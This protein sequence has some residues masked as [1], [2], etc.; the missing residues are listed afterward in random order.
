[1]R[2]YLGA[3]HRGFQLK[4]AI[5]ASVLQSGYQVIDASSTFIP[6]DDYPAIGFTVAEQTVADP[7]AVGIVCCGSGIG[8]SI[9][10][11]KIAGARAGVGYSSDQVRASR[12]DDGL[13]ILAV[14]S[15]YLSQEEALQLVEVFLRTEVGQEE[16]HLRRR[17]E[18]TLKE[19]H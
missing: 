4:E 7:A 16:R 9:A 18:I 17:Q 1:M 13:N 14:A 15:D 12:H 2:I 19:K 8:I 5:K 6:A 11:N 3:D 10:A